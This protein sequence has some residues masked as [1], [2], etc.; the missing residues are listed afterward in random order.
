MTLESR[1]ISSAFLSLALLFSARGN[2]QTVAPP[3]ATTA[4]PKLVQAAPLADDL[5][6]LHFQA[7]V[8]TQ[9]HPGF[10]AAYSG[11]HSLSSESEA[12]TSVVM[13]VFAGMRLWKGAEIYFQ[14]ELAGGRGLS[15]TE[16]IAAFSSGEVYRVGDPQPTLVLG[17]IFYRQEFGLGGGSEWVPAGVNQ[18][19]VTRDR[20]RLTFTLGKLTTT[21]IVDNEQLSNDPHT[22]F[23][24][25]GLFA[26]GAFD[27]AADTRGYTWGVAADLKI[28]RWSLRA[29]MFLEPKEA[30]GIDMEWNLG[31]ARSLTLEGEVRWAWNSRPGAARLMFYLNTA[32]M[33]NYRDAINTATPGMA[34]DVIAT[35]AQGRTKAGFAASADQQLSESWSGFARLSWNDGQNETWA[36]TEID[37]S[38][39]LGF[40]RSGAAWKRPDDEVGIGLVVSGISAVHREYLKAGGLG[41]ILGDGGLDYGPEILGELYYRLAFNKMLWLIGTYQ[42]VIDP[43]YNRAR[44]PVNI[45]SLRLHVAF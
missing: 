31:R 45:F 12:A 21:D 44:G 30:N 10:G 8:A 18:I 40:V 43:G 26:S 36:Y 23:L 28:D 27:Y 7:T 6:S 3:D 5:F 1:R 13:D 4:D 25:W 20:A 16:G 37:Q 17:R 9:G 24:S 15:S 2:S 19:G 32:D 14:P 22:R 33:G 11:Q 29:G 39:A 34:P 42:P 38:L 41:F 35:R